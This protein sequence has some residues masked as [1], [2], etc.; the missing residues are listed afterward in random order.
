MYNKPRATG[1]KSGTRTYHAYKN[2]ML[3]IVGWIRLA[4]NATAPR[5]S[6]RMTITV[7]SQAVMDL[8]TKIPPLY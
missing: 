2:G 7:N 3:R 4:N 6:R 1:V 5:Y 8:F